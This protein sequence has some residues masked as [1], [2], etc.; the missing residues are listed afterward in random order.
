MNYLTMSTKKTFQKITKLKIFSYLNF[1]CKNYIYFIL[2]LWMSKS[3][4]EGGVYIFGYGSLIW[5]TVF[6]YE[7]KYDILDLL[8]LFLKFIYCFL[9]L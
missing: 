7:H 4:E 6:E 8:F 5:R 2:V 1:I 3:E 9:E